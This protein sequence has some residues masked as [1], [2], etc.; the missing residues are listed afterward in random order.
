MV[1]RLGLESQVGYDLRALNADTNRLERL[2]A[3]LHNVSNNDLDALRH[4]I[5]SETA[6][7]P[8]SSGD[9]RERLG[10]SAAAVTY[11]VDRMI[12]AGHVRRDSDPTDRRRVILRY[13]EHGSQV[14]QAF[15]RPMRAHTQKAMADFSDEELETAHRVLAAMSSAMKS[16]YDEVVARHAE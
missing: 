3:T 16:Y 7:T 14:A 6:G 15:F 10:V 5:V 11:L 1:D 9:L 12:E 13:S 4:I 2:F 8:L